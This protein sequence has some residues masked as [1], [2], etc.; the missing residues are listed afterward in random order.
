M[1]EVEKKTGN[2]MTK[3]EQERK[4]EETNKKEGKMIKDLKK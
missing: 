3:T 4:F 1:E 2:K